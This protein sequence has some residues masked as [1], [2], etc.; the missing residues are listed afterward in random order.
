V[1]SDE[2]I[3]LQKDQQKKNDIM[4]LGFQGSPQE[5]R[6]RLFSCE[7]GDCPWVKEQWG[8]QFRWPEVDLLYIKRRLWVRIPSIPRYEW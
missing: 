5:T 3:E 6:I 7:L 4:D 2:Q 1:I 8:I